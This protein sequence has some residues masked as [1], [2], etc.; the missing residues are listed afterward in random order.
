VLYIYVVRGVISG[1]KISVE[2]VIRG[3]RAGYWGG[4]EIWKRRMEGA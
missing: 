4:K 3:G 2:K 1:W